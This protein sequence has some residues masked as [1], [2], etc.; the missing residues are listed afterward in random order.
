MTTLRAVPYWVSAAA[1]VLLL[2]LSAGLS[3]ATGWRRLAK[4]FPWP[5]KEPIDRR[6]L[7]AGLTL[8]GGW[9]PVSYWGNIVRLGPGGVGVSVVFFLRFLHP[10][11]FLPR[12]EI[13]RCLR[14]SLFRRPVTVVSLRDEKSQFVFYGR[15]G[16][17][18]FDSFR[19]D[20]G[21]ADA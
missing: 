4:R 18:V 3:R 8:A 5:K 14:T 7:L 1:L 15:A 11:I 17:A 19:T 16:D 13:S 9:F 2:L 20:Q 6:F 12:S 10:P 21:G